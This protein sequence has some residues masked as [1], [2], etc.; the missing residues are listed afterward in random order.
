MFS[1][2]CAYIV[3]T[4]YLLTFKAWQVLSLFHFIF[5]FKDK[6]SAWTNVQ[7]ISNKKGMPSV[8][9]DEIKE[10]LDIFLSDNT[11]RF[12]LPGCNDQIYIG[13]NEKVF[14]DQKNY[15]LWTFS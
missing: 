13:K 4:V 5:G 1:E 9:N 11:N 8:L 14:L 10:K 3:L 6:C 2:D 12:T 7:G 15:V